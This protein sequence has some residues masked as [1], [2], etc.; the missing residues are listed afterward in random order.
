MPGT[1]SWVGENLKTV[2]CRQQNEP[3]TLFCIFLKTTRPVIVRYFEQ[4]FTINNKKFKS[5]CLYPLL[6]ALNK[7]RPTSDTK[8]KKIHYDNARPHIHFS[9]KKY[10]KSKPL[11]IMNHP[12][13]SPYLRPSDFWL[14]EFKTSF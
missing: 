10:I 1:Q 14:F 3:K 8:N 7:Q 9:V 6:N 2:V 11:I 13:Y 5:N 4:G 12:L